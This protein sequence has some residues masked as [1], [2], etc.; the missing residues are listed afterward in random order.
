MVLTE[1]YNSLRRY[2]INDMKEFMKD[3]YY[4][5]DDLIISGLDATDNTFIGDPLAIDGFSVMIMISGTARISINTN[6]YRVSQSDIIFFSPNCI[7]KALDQSEDAVGVTISASKSFMNE[8]QIDLQTLLG[9]YMRFGHNPVL[10]VSQHDIDEIIELIK[11]IRLMLSSDRR[12]YKNEIIR[13]LFTTI[14]YILSDLNRR[15]RVSHPNQRR[16]SQLFE[17]FMSLLSQYNTKERNVRFYAEKLGISTKYLSALVKGVSGKTAA[18]WIDESVILEAKSL[19]LYSGMSISDIT[20]HLN[21]STQSFFGKFF[22]QH[23]GVSPTR[24][25]RIAQQKS[26]GQEII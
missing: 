2:S 4:L 19:L 8:L 5:S 3:V 11:M 22:K 13:T 1:R 24:F 25:K 18:K 16:A 15:D 14:F 12:Y 6:E 23:T 17:E 10:H 20:K 26:S 9:I 21:F 7:I